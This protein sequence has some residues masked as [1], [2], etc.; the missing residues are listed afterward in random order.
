M[1]Q[2]RRNI[3]VKEKVQERLRQKKGLKFGMWIEHKASQD[4][5]KRFTIHMLEN[6]LS[7]CLTCLPRVCS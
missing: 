4:G 2:R 5:L 3:E 7:G 1:R 6:L